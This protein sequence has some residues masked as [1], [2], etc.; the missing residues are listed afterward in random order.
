MIFK[1]KQPYLLTIASGKG[2]VGKSV[3]TANIAH[4]LAAKGNKVLVLDADIMCPNQHLLFGI[5]PILRIDDWFYKRTSAARTIHYIHD[6]LGLIA[7]ALDSRNIMLQDEISFLDLFQELLLNT[8]FDYIMADTSA[9]ITKSLVE[10][11]SL[12]DKVGIVVTDEP[13]SI[14]D[15]YGLIKILREYVDAHSI[16]LILNNII[17][18]EDAADISEKFNMATKH[19]MDI[20]LDIL[21]V[22]PYNRAVR[23]SILRQELLADILPDIN[24]VNAMKNITQALKAASNL[25]K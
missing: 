19:F 13:T 25:A 1:A 24:A 15:A 16:N 23:Q 6:N 3:I 18:D 17:D 10:C 21:G 9:G 11:C 2:G 20:T 7:G 22:I 5:D 12:S 8:D 4:I 14:L